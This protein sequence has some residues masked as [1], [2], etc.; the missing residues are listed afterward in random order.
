MMR[1]PCSA[2][3]DCIGRRLQ[4]STR[5]I[6]SARPLALLHPNTYSAVSHNAVLIRK[7]VQRLSCHARRA[8]CSQKYCT[9]LVA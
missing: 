5:P 3:T 2:P 6:N 4:G 8:V 7:S 9:L 1:S